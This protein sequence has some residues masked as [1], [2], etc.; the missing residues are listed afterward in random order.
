MKNTM[1]KCV[2]LGVIGALLLCAGPPD[3]RAEEPAVQVSDIDKAL[4]LYEVGKD[5]LRAGDP[6]GALQQ[7]KAALKLA[8]GDEGLTW[9][10]L[11]AVAVGYR[12]ADQPANAIEY[13][14]RFLAQTESF[15]DSMTSKWTSRRERAA[16]DLKDLESAVEE[17]HGAVT[18]TSTPKGAAVFL[19]E[20]R[21]GADG[22]VVTPFS[23][24]L[25]PGTYELKLKL[26]GF[27]TESRT[28][29][30]RPGGSYP[31]K[32]SMTSLAPAPVAPSIREVSPAPEAAAAGP[33][34]AQTLSATASEPDSTGPFIL[35]GAG[36]AL[37]LVG[38]IFTGLAN[39]EFDALQA[40]TQPD[41]ATE[42]V[43][44]A[45]AWQANKGT[46]Q[47]YETLMWVSYGAAAAAAIGGAIWLALPADTQ[48]T[49]SPHLPQLHI[50]PHHAGLTGQATWSF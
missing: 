20:N 30:V 24:W 6:R 26:E 10:M 12:Q 1:M 9:Q 42:A 5:A 11:L 14:R 17:T 44:A 13:F 35:M 32:F 43:T 31:F 23:F 16:Q 46:L 49:A 39:R 34:A 2:L 36:G 45:T 18:V 40:Q 48:Q 8:E 19:G 41:Q 4:Q 33:E 47:T 7:F 3:A 29:T 22:D 15:K 25:K 28:I 37:A 50:S 27:K 38:A 21:A